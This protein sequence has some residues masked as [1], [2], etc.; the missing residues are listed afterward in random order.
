MRVANRYEGA[1]TNTSFVAKPFGMASGWHI[2]AV[3]TAA[4]A[5]QMIRL[6][7]HALDQGMHAGKILLDTFQLAHLR[8]CVLLRFDMID[9]L[10]VNDNPARCGTGRSATQATYTN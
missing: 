1:Y 5:K 6:T 8:K 2:T 4:D 9:F 7:I 3:P 10:T